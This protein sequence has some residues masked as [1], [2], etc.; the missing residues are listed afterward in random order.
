MTAPALPL[1]SGAS[2]ALQAMP[3]RVA[4]LAGA[5]AT[6]FCVALAGL[7]PAAH[8]AAG[9]AAAAPGAA[10]PGIGPQPLT[11]ASPHIEGD[12]TQAEAI[13]RLRDQAAGDAWCHAAFTL[14]CRSAL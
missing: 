3:L 9:P 2:P 8:A 7:P 10:Q 6:A 14:C 13:R 4:A 5:F 11:A 1:H 12:G